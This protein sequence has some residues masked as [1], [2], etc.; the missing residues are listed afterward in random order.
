MSFN[1]IGEVFF[2]LCKTVDSP[3][4]LGAW[5]RYKYDEG[6][7]AEFAILPKD[8]TLFDR[9]AGDYLVSSFLSKYESLKTGIDLKAVTLRKFAKSEAQCRAT[10]GKFRDP[11]LRGLT[12]RAHS[13]LH[14]MQRKIARILGEFRLKHVLRECRWGKGATSTIPRR[15]STLDNKICELPLSVTVGALPFIRLELE[16]DPHWFAALTGIFPS[17]PYSV[18]SSCFKIV[19]G[20]KLAQ[21]PKNAKTNRM[22]A[23]EPTAN[24][25][26]QQGVGRYIRRCLK[27]YGID[28]DNQE[29]N[30]KYACSA[31]LRRLA[32][33]DLSAASDTI[34]RLLVEHLLPPD[35][36]D[37]LNSIRSWYYTDDQGKTHWSEKF[38]SMGNAF[39]FELETL[40]F[41]AATSCIQDEVDPNGVVSIYG[42]DIICEQNIA[43]DVISVLEELGFTINK[44]KSYVDGEFFESCGVHTYQ[45]MDVT[46]VFQKEDYRVKDTTCLIRLANRLLRYSERQPDWAT[47][48]R[49][50]NAARQVVA[51]HAGARWYRFATPFAEGDDGFRL[52]RDELTGAAIPYDA[53]RGYRCTVLTPVPFLKQGNEPALLAWTLRRGVK[54][55]T[56]FNGRVSPHI[57]EGLRVVKRERWIAPT[58][59]LGE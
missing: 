44:E 13:I 23:T 55:E 22:I 37:Y 21:V 43:K 42:D 51:R 49:L 57:A 12:P 15:R 56:P 47:T 8:Y 39:T 17:G 16:H 36:Y 6:Q 27:R 45:G 53:N 31:Y 26:L 32:T 48:S 4:S 29:T 10:N 18:V 14:A 11:L 24:S 35:W 7:L 52:R 59:Q 46:P 5:L 58:W 19:S 2:A 34:A 9:F 54:T 40:I 3:V 41:Y 20:N 50:C 28:L 33:L 1:P 38:S 25:F 30:Q